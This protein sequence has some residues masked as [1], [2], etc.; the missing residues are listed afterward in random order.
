[1]NV[2][3]HLESEASIVD[4]FL[5]DEEHDKIFDFIDER[6]IEEKLN[7]ITWEGFDGFSD[8]WIVSPEENGLDRFTFKVEDFG[9]KEAN[10]DGFIYYSKRCYSRMQLKKYLPKRLWN[11]LTKLNMQDFEITKL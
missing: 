11:L 5:H 7:N 2:K 4:L 1:M 6:T 10:E 3:I 8:V 9:N